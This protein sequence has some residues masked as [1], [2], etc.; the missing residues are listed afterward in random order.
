M[1]DAIHQKATILIVDDTPANLDLVG[2][3]L[4]DHYQL[5]IANSGERAL[6]LLEE[7]SLPDLI[8]LD[9]VMPGLSGWDVCSQ[10]KQNPLLKDIPV[11][12][13]TAQAEVQDETRGFEVGAVDYIT[14]PIYPAT[15]LARVKTHLRLKEVADYLKDNNT[16]LER[17]GQKRAEEL[18]E[19]K[20]QLHRL[21]LLK[22]FFSEAVAN[23]IMQPGGEDLLKP[24]RKEVSIVF[25]ELKGFNRIV[26][27]AEP[28][29]VLEILRDYHR[30]VDEQASK[31]KGT[32]DRFGNSNA[33]I[34]FND[35]APVEDFSVYALNMAQEVQRLFQ[36]IQEKW[37]S[38][39]LN[40]G[41]G[42]GVARG[43]A[44]LGIIGSENRVDY[45]AIGPV[46]NLAA[47]LCNNAKDGEIIFDL[48]TYDALRLS[49]EITKI[50]FVS[51][52]GFVR[53]VETFKLI[54]GAS[55]MR[56]MI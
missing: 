52:T 38:L 49:H 46:T 1:P 30:I 19:Q 51:L 17:E 15:L 32:I 55:M 42:V 12:F 16:L 14:K 10:L 6:K 22:R 3:L 26:S 33:M 7:K 21:G 8:L 4:G 56:K 13:L 34:I 9:V 39:K 47:N 43:F 50:G 40:I 54:R 35:P 23:Q 24:H 53:P 27:E 48:K 29:E 28:E 18:L 41:V 2:G 11:I 36:D 5:K 37:K 25:C 45:A 20:E 31:F 44:T